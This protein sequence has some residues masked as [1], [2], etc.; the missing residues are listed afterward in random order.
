MSALPKLGISVGHTWVRAFATGCAIFAALFLL[1]CAAQLAPT[2][3]EQVDQRLAALNQRIATFVAGVPAGGYPPETFQAHQAFY[4][5]TLGEIA[6][7]KARASARPVPRPLLAEW[8]GLGPPA[9]EATGIGQDIPTVE[10]LELVAEGVRDL[11]A[12]HS[13]PSGLSPTF[14]ER[15]GEQIQIAMNNAITY[16]LAL[17]R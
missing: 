9:A 4:A 15:T 3:D 8:L 13:G 1:G 16:E 2:Y 7:L 14:A 10:S 12:A 6:A 11:R 17:R 5:D